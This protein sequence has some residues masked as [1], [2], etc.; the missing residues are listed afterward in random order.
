MSK[1][2]RNSSLKLQSQKPDVPIWNFGWS[3]FPRTDRI[4]VGFEI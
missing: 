2:K 1:V 4:R 3:D